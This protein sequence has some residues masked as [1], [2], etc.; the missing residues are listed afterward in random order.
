MGQLFSLSHSNDEYIFLKFPHAIPALTQI[1][2][3]FPGDEAAH[4]INLSQCRRLPAQA[5]AHRRNPTATG[6]S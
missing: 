1:R 6:A 3:F 4:H 5:Q 2:S